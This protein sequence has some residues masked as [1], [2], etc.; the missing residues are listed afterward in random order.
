SRL[1][2]RSPARA[3]RRWT[4]E[5]SGPEPRRCYD[6]IVVNAPVL[7][8]A[9]ER[10]SLGERLALATLVETRGATPQKAGARILVRGDGGSLG[11]LGG[12]AV[13]AAAVPGAARGVGWGEPLLC[14]SPLSTGTDEWGLACGGTMLVFVEPLEERALGWLPAVVDAA[15]GG[16]PVAVVTLLDGPRAGSR[17]V[18]RES[19]SG[20]SL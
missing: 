2:A 13:E 18:V 7:R 20:G 1:R 14:E 11:T 17:L 10:L 12:G 15:S 6:G 8:E 3:S 16:D 19:R 5:G 9:L 4:G